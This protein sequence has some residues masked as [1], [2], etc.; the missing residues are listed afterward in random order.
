MKKILLLMFLLL[1]PLSTAYTS[2]NVHIDSGGNALFLGES[3]E[4]IIE[5]LPSGLSFEGGKLLGE[6]SELTNKSGDVWNF[7]FS[8]TDGEMQVFL[9]EGARVLKTNGEISLSGKQ[10][11]VYGVS[12][13]NIEYVVEGFD[14][15]GEM[16]LGILLILGILVAI[17][18]YLLVKEG[19]RTRKE[20]IPNGKEDKIK[21]IE[22]I[23]NER[24]K[25]ILGKL[26]G[27]GKIKSSYLRR[28]TEIP[29]ASFS[30]HIRELEK[31]GLV[32]ISGDGRN[33][34]VELN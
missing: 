3:D 14:D 31:K 1:I 6:T 2:L 28:K 27:A 34:F 18:V 29:K 10:I 13:V 4:T 30:R 17:V 7:L 32:K 24:E 20:R 8:L 9:P 23:L 16:D 21:A 11:V 15:N 12:Y 5:G 22:G 25:L 33:K 26:K 19:G